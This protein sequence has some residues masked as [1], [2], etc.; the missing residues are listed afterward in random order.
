MKVEWKENEVTV[1]GPK[2]KLVR[3]ID[4]I[5]NLRKDDGRLMVSPSGERLEKGETKSLYGLTRT[6]LENMVKGVSEGFS[7]TLELVGTGY[8]VE[9]KG[10]SAI[11]LEVGYSHRV[12]FPL[13]EGITARVGEKNLKVTIEGIDKEVV[14]QVAANIREIKPPEPYKG[15]GI[16]YEGERIRRK[17]GKAGKAAGTKVT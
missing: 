17:A 16:K 3:R 4:P 13:P 6:L 10:K 2:G 11:E 12:H 14:G 5:F 7:R 8:K 9:A 1:S 15:K